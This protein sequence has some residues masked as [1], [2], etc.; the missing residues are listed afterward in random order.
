MKWGMSNGTVSAM[1]LSDLISSKD[2]PWSSLFDPSRSKAVVESSK[3]FIGTNIGIVKKLLSGIIPLPE[4]IDPSILN[5]GEGKVI[6]VGE[7]E[8]GAYK[9]E[10]G[11]IY[12][13]SVA[14]THLGCTVTWNNAEKTWDCPCHGSRFNYDGSVIH[15]PALMRLKEYKYLEKV[16]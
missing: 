9:D 3:D 10:N 15:A 6:K 7:K 13:V 11:K 16:K 14:C 5:E 12:L 8:L 1:I 4:S 2:N